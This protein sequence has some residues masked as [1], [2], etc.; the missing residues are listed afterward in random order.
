MKEY[1]SADA[2]ASDI[3]GLYNNSLMQAQAAALVSVFSADGV[4]WLPNSSNMLD[5]VIEELR[6]LSTNTPG[7]QA[8]LNEMRKQNKTTQRLITE[9]RNHKARDSDRH[10]R[11]SQSFIRRCDFFC[12]TLQNYV[13]EPICSVQEWI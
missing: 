12:L 7:L 10:D 13:N 11:Y 8:L 6:K 3:I 9:L 4:K 2:P 5:R 1:Q